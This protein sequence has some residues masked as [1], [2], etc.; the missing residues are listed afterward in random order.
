MIYQ[1]PARL[2]FLLSKRNLPG[3]FFFI[4]LMKY[5]F[6]PQTIE[7]Q[8]VLLLKKGLIIEDIPKASQILSSI[9]YFRIKRYTIPFH[10]SDGK[11]DYSFLPNIYFDD[12][13]DIYKFD[14]QLRVIIFE[15][16]ASIEIAFKAFLNYTMTMKYGSHWYLDSSLFKSEFVSNLDPNYESGYE[17]FIYKL[18]KECTESHENFV[19]KYRFLYTDPLL[20]PSWIV[21]E[22]M[23]FGM[24]CILYQNIS[25]TEARSE[26][27]AN[28]KINQKIFGTWLFNLSYVRNQCAHH[29]KIMERTFMFPPI[30]PKREQNRFLTEYKDIKEDSLYAV[31]W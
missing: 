16:I 21:L 14:A 5:S 9:G 2:C 3:L 12:I 29:Q 23:S 26:V 28:F 1:Y 10:V 6:S 17:K 8:T 22:I 20:P 30:F 19:R 25:N 7:Q 11:G 27:S 13:V 24:S 31:L 15:A 18:T 4:L